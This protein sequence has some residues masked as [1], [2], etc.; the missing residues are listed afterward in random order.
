MTTRKWRTA[1]VCYRGNNG[2]LISCSPCVP[3]RKHSARLGDRIYQANIEDILEQWHKLN[4][5]L[6]DVTSWL[7]RV[8]PE[9]E[10]L[11]RMAP[12]TSMQDL[13][14]QIRKLKEMQRTFNSHKCLMMSVNL[15]SHHFLRTDGTELQELQEVLGSA[16][17]SWAQACSALEN[18]QRKLYHAVLQCQEFHEALGS[19][20]LLLSEAEKKLHDVSIYRTPAPLKRDMLREELQSRLHQVSALQEISS[21]LL[22]EATS[23]EGLEAKEKVNVIRNKLQLLLQK[24]AAQLGS[25]QEVLVDLLQNDCR[26]WSLALKLSSQRMQTSMWRSTGLRQFVCLW[27]SFPLAR[28]DV[29]SRLLRAAFSIHLLVLV[30]LVLVL[31]VPL[32]D[33]DHSCMLSN[34]FARSF[35][36][37]LHYTNGP[38]PT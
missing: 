36:P 22:V 17:H 15:R 33:Q 21:L 10:R 18:W 4:C 12:P 38:P 14:A 29:F 2:N 20:L 5:E 11:Q 16:S 27:S 6:C 1:Q 35:H 19:L 28:R 30:L 3:C 26:E 34:N 23:E 32:S 13:E 8:L 31:L 24:V 25:L 37:M 9:L 7:S